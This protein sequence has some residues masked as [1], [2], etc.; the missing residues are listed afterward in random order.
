MIYVTE[1]LMMMAEHRAVSCQLPR[2]IV[3]HQSRRSP[4]LLSGHPASLQRDSAP[5]TSFDR[6][7]HRGESG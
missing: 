1:Q 2:S 4:L 7:A 5:T 3:N 6:A